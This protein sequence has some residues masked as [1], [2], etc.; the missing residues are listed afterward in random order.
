MPTSDTEAFPGTF[1][2]FLD[3]AS[4]FLAKVF[5]LSRD[6]I[7]FLLTPNISLSIFFAFLKARIYL[8]IYLF[9]V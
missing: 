4:I 7:D 8:F 1:D 3:K 2:M 6:K 5:Y 9:L